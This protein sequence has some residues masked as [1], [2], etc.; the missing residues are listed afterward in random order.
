MVIYDLDCAQ[1]HRF[2]GW[3]QDLD[4]FRQQEAAGQLECPSCGS[5]QVR[6][7]VTGSAIKRSAEGRADSNVY[8]TP[9]PA[10]APPQL[11]PAQV[12]EVMGMVAAHVRANAEDVGARFAEEARRIHRE[13]AAPRLIRG[14]ATEQEERELEEEEIPFLKVPDLATDD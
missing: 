4:A 6:K 5:R 7:L 11:T 2:E 3:F 1:G 10:G 12:R 13:E 8:P 14:T 9:E